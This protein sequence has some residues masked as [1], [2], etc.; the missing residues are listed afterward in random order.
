MVGVRAAWIAITLFHAYPWIATSYAYQS[1]N[2]VKVSVSDKEADVPLLGRRGLPANGHPLRGAASCA[3]SSCHGGPQPGVSAL[4]VPRGSEHARW[5]EYDPHANA[6][7]TLCSDQSLQIMT[8]LGIFQNGQISNIAAYENCL[9]CH[10]TDRKVSKDGTHP[11]LMEGVGCEACHGAANAWIDKHFQSEQAV[12]SA[13][14]E[15]GLSDLGTWVQRARLCVDCHVGASDRDMN[16]DMIAAGHPALYFDMAVYYESY[17]KHWRDTEQNDVALRAKLWLAGQ[18]ANADAE[19]ELLVSRAERSNPVSVWPELSL[20]DCARCHQALDGRS[21]TFVARNTAE[22]G[23][24]APVRMWNLAGIHALQYFPHREIAMPQHWDA[25]KTQL[26]NPL[27]DE[28]SIAMT[29]HELRQTIA[30]LA[31][32][33]AAGN[34]DFW[35]QR[36]QSQHAA[37]LLEDSAIHESWEP[38][39]AAYLAAWATLP[40]H[41]DPKLEKALVDLRKALLFP[42]GTRSPQFPS[43]E[44]SDRTPNSDSWVTSLRDAAREVLCK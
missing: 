5:K 1:G 24:G 32:S 29:A 26:E 8:R 16:H 21:Q 20:Y 7:S 22:R 36:S 2:I 38:A 17:P 34:L 28:L 37:S 19:L 6:W 3:A 42:V 4:S 9:A 40:A 12:A 14:R 39:A 18:I 35:S 44:R 25:L 30:R 27:R 43:Q 23:V 31:Q 41:R 13:K 10:N 11:R 15:F 33:S